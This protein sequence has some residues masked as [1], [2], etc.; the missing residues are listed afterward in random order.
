MRGM[1]V[2]DEHD[3]QRQVS[4]N[5]QSRN[6]LSSNPASHPSFPQPNYQVAREHSF[7]SP[8]NY[9]PY[10]TNSEPPA[11]TSPSVINGSPAAAYSNFS[12]LDLHRRPG[13]LYD[14]HANPRLPAPSFYYPQ[15]LLY[16]HPGPSPAATP[17][18]LSLGNVSSTDKM[19]LQVCWKFL[20]LKIKLKCWPVSYNAYAHADSYDAPH[21]PYQWQFRF[22]G[23]QFNA[24]SICHVSHFA[25]CTSR[26]R[27]SRRHASLYE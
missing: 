16:G 12:A 26:P 5:L 15:S 11:Y 9:D 22:D 20:S 4:L 2:E 19:E 3:F 13:F 6:H 24:P 17:Q 14:Y 1:V 8:F 27:L 25:V 10:R 18:T 7:D 23:H 21:P